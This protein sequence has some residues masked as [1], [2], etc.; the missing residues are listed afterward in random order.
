MANGGKTVDTAV[1]KKHFTASPKVL[2]FIEANMPEDGNY[3]K[4]SKELFSR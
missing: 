2:E 3:K 1:V 4:F